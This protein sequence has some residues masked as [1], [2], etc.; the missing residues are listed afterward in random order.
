MDEQ[1][2]LP[3]NTRLGAETYTAMVTSSLTDWGLQDSAIVPF[4]LGP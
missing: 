2:V 3:K 4:L 1:E